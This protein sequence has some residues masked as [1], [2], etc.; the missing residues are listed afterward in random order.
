MCNVFIRR[1]PSSTRLDLFFSKLT[2]PPAAIAVFTDDRCLVCEKYDIS[3]ACGTVVVT[4]PK[5]RSV[6]YTLGRVYQSYL[7]RSK[8]TT[9]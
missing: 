2:F 6:G 7:L 4:T 8:D 3:S 5:L 9:L 1:E